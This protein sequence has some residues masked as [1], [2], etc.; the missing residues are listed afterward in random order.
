MDDV[1]RALGLVQSD[2][3]SPE[4]N[5]ECIRISRR[6]VEAGRRVVGLLPASPRVAVP[7]LGVRLGV[8]LVQL[9]GATVAYIDANVRYPALSAMAES[10]ASDDSVYTTRW[11]TGTLALLTPPHVEGAGEVV[12]Q[13]ARVVGEG[14]ELFQYMLVD[15]TGIDRVGDHSAAA[16]LMDGVIVVGKAGKTKEAELRRLREDFTRHQMLGVLLYG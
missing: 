11:L 16:S 8:S 4:V 5:A 6:L 2:A 14:A 9:T 13:L 12:P 1:L 3:E 7:P 10:K 15:L